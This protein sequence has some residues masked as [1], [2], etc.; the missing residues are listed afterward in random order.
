MDAHLSATFDLS[1][2]LG[3]ARSSEHSTRGPK[4]VDLNDVPHLKDV[5]IGT[6]QEH[7]VKTPQFLSFH[8][9]PLSTQ[10]LT[11]VVSYLDVVIQVE[12]LKKKVRQAEGGVVLEEDIAAM[13]ELQSE[14]PAHLRAIGSKYAVLLTKYSD[15][16]QPKEELYFFEMLYEYVR[17][18]CR[19]MFDS[20]YGKLVDVEIDRLFR[21]DSFNRS[22]RLIEVRERDVL[23]KDGELALDANKDICGLETKASK[24]D[25]LFDF[26]SPEEI[27]CGQKGASEWGMKRSEEE[28]MHKLMTSHTPLLMHVLPPPESETAVEKKPKRKKGE[29]HSQKRVRITECK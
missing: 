6:L 25:G 23:S 16:R 14:Y 10:F 27:V 11:R 9:S 8:R 19:R 12:K 17:N 15:I 20:F 22:R 26:P 3:S 7:K 13:T 4:T 18:V 1:S 21:T 2:T 28:R 5:A 24:K 29:Q